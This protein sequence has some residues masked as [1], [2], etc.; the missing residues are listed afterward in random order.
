MIRIVFFCVAFTFAAH[1][2]AE[3]PNGKCNVTKA[4]ANTVRNVAKGTVRVVKPRCPNGKCRVGTV[5]K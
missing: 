2:N 4:T 1:A 5:I 3:C